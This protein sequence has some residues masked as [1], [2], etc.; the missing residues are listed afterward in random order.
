MNRLIPAMLATLVL[1]GCGQ[2]GPLYMP[3]DE[4]SSERYDPQGAYQ[5][6]DV[7]QD[8]VQQDDAQQGGVQQGD[9]QQGDVR[10]N[11]DADRTSQS[12]SDGISTGGAGSE[13]QG[14]A[15]SVPEGNS[16]PE[17]TTGGTIGGAASTE[18][19]AAPAQGGT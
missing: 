5:Q 9:V 3:G 11:D 18:A 16:R 12:T 17:T 6:D 14:G 13:S 1:A 10:Q 15:V 19:P 7:Q 2:T 8:D 4:Q